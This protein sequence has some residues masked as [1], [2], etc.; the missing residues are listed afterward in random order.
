M[1]YRCP[2]CYKCWHPRHGSKTPKV[3]PWCKTEGK[4]QDITH[5]AHGETRMKE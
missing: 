3:C 2:A 1:P 4:Q 5:L